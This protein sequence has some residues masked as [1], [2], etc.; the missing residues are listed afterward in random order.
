M[1]AVLSNCS[2]FRLLGKVIT[3]EIMLAVLGISPI[4]MPLQE[5]LLT[6]RP[7]VSVLPE[8]KLIKL[9]VAVAEAARAFSAFWPSFPVLSLAF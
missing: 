6:C 9:L 3:C 4:M 5:P 2:S 1:S 8:Q 7:F